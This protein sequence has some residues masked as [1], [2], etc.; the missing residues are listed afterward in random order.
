MFKLFPLSDTKICSEYCLAYFQ[1][2]FIDFCKLIIS[3]FVNIYLIGCLF[4]F[5][6]KHC[7]KLIPSADGQSLRLPCFTS[8]GSNCYFECA[9][10]FSMKGKGV[11]SC[12]ILSESGSVSWETNKFFCESKITTS[13]FDCFPCRHF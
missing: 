7:K 4:F 8:F 3:L 6:A 9:R 5:S 12:S 1:T 2:V 10:G 11:A 13:T